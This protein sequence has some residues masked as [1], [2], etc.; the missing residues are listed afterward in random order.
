MASLCFIWLYLA[1]VGFILLHLALTGFIWHHPA[2]C[3]VIWLQ[4]ASSGFIWL[5][6]ASFGFIWASFGFIWASFGRAAGAP[7]CDA[8]L[9]Q[10]RPRTSTSNRRQADHSLGVPLLQQDLICAHRAG[11]TNLESPAGGSQP[12]RTHP[13]LRPN[14]RA[15]IYRAENTNLRS[16]TGGS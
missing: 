3:G 1:F 5:H 7:N 2:S 15:L 14:L 6:L 11:N 8:P 4:L 12:G 10:D 9:L 16:P 13:S